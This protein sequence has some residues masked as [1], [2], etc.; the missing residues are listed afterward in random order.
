VAYFI[1]VTNLISCWIIEANG[2]KA[3]RLSN[4]MIV[5]LSK[6]ENVSEGQSMLLIRPEDIKLSRDKYIL[7]L[8]EAKKKKLLKGPYLKKN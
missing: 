7:F 8:I 1:G 3:I 4:G 6:I 2:K 5:Q